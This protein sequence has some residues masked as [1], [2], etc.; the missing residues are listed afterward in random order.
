MR[1]G[2]R[3]NAK[4]ALTALA[5]V[6]GLPWPI[7]QPATEPAIVPSHTPPTLEDLRAAIAAAPAGAAGTNAPPA[8]T[9]ALIGLV[10][11]LD[12]Q[13]LIARLVEGLD[14][15]DRRDPSYGKVLRVVLAARSPLANTSRAIELLSYGVF[16]WAV[17]DWETRLAYLLVRSIPIEA[18]DSWRQLDNGKWLGRLLDN[19]P[20]D[21][22]ESG[23]YTGVGSEYS[24]G[25]VNLGVPETMLLGYAKGY[26]QLWEAQAHSLLAKWIVRNLLALDF[27]GDP[28]PWLPTDAAKD[29]A[30]RTAVI[31]RLDALQG[32]NGIIEKL[33]DDYLLGEQTRQELL[34]LNQLR[35][36]VHLVRQALGLMPGFFG[37]I[38]FT[39]HD[40]WIALQA[41]RALS[42]AAQQQLAAQNPSVWSTFWEGLTDEM[43]RSLPSTLATGRDARL[44]TRAALRERLS[45]ERLWTQ[46]NAAV[47]RALIDLA[48]AADDRLWVFELS[49][50]LRI[51]LKVAQAPLVA[52]VLRDFG[53]YSVAER[54]TVFEPRRT[55]SSH[56]PMGLRSLGVAAKGLALLAYHLFASDAEISLMGKTMHLKAFDLTD[57]QW[58]MGGDF[59]G[60]TLGSSAG[61]ANHVNVDATFADGFIVNLDMPRLDVAGV[62]MV[63]P[64]KSYKAGPLTIEG[65]KVSA[66]FSDRGYTRPGYIAA[67][68]DALALRDFVVIDPTLPLAG[69]WA[70]AN[71]GVNRLGF[72]A[73]PDGATDPS[74][75]IGRDLPKGTIPIPV[76]GPLFQLLSNIVSLKGSIPGD[77]TLL[78]YAMLPLKL[79]F[80]V[81]TAASFAANKAIPTP[82]PATYL[83][84]LASDGVLRPPYS[85]AQRIK[86][87]TAMLRAF[88]VAFDKLEVK[89]ITIGA[90]QQI[91][92]LTLTD[93]NITVGQSLPAYLRAALATVHAARVKAPADSPQSIELEQRERAL[94]KQLDAALGEDAADEKRLQALEG[95]DRWHPGSLSTEDRAELVRL[96][97]KLRSDVGVVAEI[98]SISLGPLT[99]AVQ[100]PGVTLTG[101]HARAKLPNLGILPYAPGYL[102]DKSLI[103]QFAE[104][105]PKVPTIGEL[106]KTSEFHLEIDE[107]T[108]AKTDPAQ[109][110]VVLRA[111]TIPSVEAL[112][113]EI[114]ALPVIEGN[115][116]IRQR[117]TQ[118]LAAVVSLQAAKTDVR[119][120]TTDDARRAAEQRVRELTELARRL[121]GTEIGGLKFGRITGDLDPAGNLSVSVNDIE[122][123]GIAGRG[124]A[125]DK[126]V[127]TA[128]IGLAAGNIDARLDQVGAVSPQTLVTQLKPAFGLSGLTV[129]GVHLPSGS[130]GRVVLGKL[131]GTLVTNAQGYSV[132]NLV[133]DHLEVGDVA[134]GRDGDGI[135][136]EAVTIDDLRF[137]IDVTIGRPA[138][139][140]PAVTGAVIPNLTIG[141]LSGRGIV[142]D[143]PQPDGSTTHI[144][145]SRGTLRDIR[146]TDIAFA[147][148]SKGWQLV[149]AKATVGSFEDV[150]FQLAMGALSSR[151]T[152][153][154][155]LTT[156]TKGRSG[157]P[158]FS[159]SYAQ[160]DGGPTVSLRVRDLLARGTDV[161]TPDGSLTVRSVRVAADY[162]SDPKGGRA[163]ASF[164]GLVIGPIRW[165]VGT[166][167][168]SGDGPLT[169]DYT[170]LAAVQTP[171]VPA[172]GKKPA[173]PAA[174]TV[175]DVVITKL[176]GRKLNW[177]DKPLSL[178][179]GRSDRTGTGEPP[180]TVGRIHLRPAA[181]SFELADLAVD[182]EGKITDTLGVKGS[183]SADFISVDVLRG[184]KLHAVVRGV[185]GSASLSG[186]YTGTVELSGLQGAAV[187]VGPDAIRI[188]SD[189]PAETGGLFIEQ[190]SAHS[191]DITTVVGGHKA[192]LFTQPP[193]MGKAGGRIDLLGIRTRVR[194]DKR[195]PPEKGKSPFKTL[196]FETFTI[197][198]IVLDALQVDLPDDD[199]S[200]VIQ[201]TATAA[202]E[203][204]IRNLELTSPVGTDRA[205]LH[206]DFT[207]DLDTFK[208]EGTASIAG[209][210]AGVSAKIKDK[211]TGDVRFS[212]GKSDLYLYAG[213]GMRIDVTKPLVELKKAADIGGGRSVR[214]G[215]LGAESLSYTDDGHL[216]V[217]KPFASDLEYIQL[218]PGTSSRAV[219]IKVK[220][221]DL[222]QLDYNT[223]GGGSLSIPSLDIT[224]AFFSL[225]LGALT[226]KKPGDTAD[227]AA[228]TSSFDPKSLRPAMNELNGSLG[229]ELYVSSDIFGLKDIHIGTDSKPLVVPIVAGELDIPTFESNIKGA[230]HAVQ[231]GE[232]LYL[233]P[234]VVNAVANDPLLAIH[235]NRLELG[236][237][238]VNP[239]TGVEKGNDVNEKNR[240]RTKLWKPI[241]SWDLRAADLAR[242]WSNKF[243]LWSAVFDMH[244]DP[245]KTDEDLAK[246]S[247]SDRKE[248]EEDQK[249]AKEM[250]KSLEI[251]KLDAAFSMRNDRPIPIPISSETVKGSIML[252][253]DAL[254]N[255][256]VKGGIP[257]EVTPI[258][259]PGTNPGK[260][261]L[262][263]DFFNLDSV[264]LTIY[265]YAPPD[266]KG[267][268]AK[269]TGMSGLRTGKITIDTLENASV[270]FF[271]LKHPGRLTGTIKKAHAENISWSKY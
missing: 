127:G 198:R 161:T 140:A 56:V 79:P 259:R 62:N 168:L 160:G 100:S 11:A 81:S 265:D 87:S 4:Q 68:F 118:A 214:V 226:K 35:D 29:L 242:A 24:T 41:L 217:K 2:G 44:P 103:D 89:G 195:T 113:A 213:G 67:K 22:W 199:V 151:T 145:A 149:R 76:F 47:L 173:R 146:G 241:L 163:T 37:L 114:D 126:A 112:Q 237:Y 236:V 172:V 150:G 135:Q 254:L 180:L 266:K 38:T 155:T 8:T 162:A 253:K 247:E 252:G 220:T 123:T 255:L 27:S 227:D 121:L 42:P 21:M 101:I 211:F 268:P 92:S 212:A 25:A 3:D 201:R 229:V 261:D 142:M 64:G 228:S 187:D 74:V 13:G 12:A 193:G 232:G 202:D 91:A 245:P 69:A 240:P 166:A 120:A 221:V 132:P 192:H 207:I 143:S 106:A 139:G 224:D 30:L 186:D 130:I 246:L 256:R 233:R 194:I 219:W 248:Y 84:G 260:L 235:S 200:I 222:K 65:F 156:A 86:D 73:T 18:Q 191:L 108:L 107:T 129:T 157:Q 58:M 134:M 171:P 94:Q 204:F 133:V 49:R 66:G 97:K 182:V 249:A 102:D 57:V 36:P 98:G 48:V 39:P 131:T 23:E 218:V 271:D 1:E 128:S 148:D 50:R 88:N 203:T 183:L 257:A 119:D 179:L 181:K 59:D 190:L 71:L 147:A 184:D 206:P 158:T 60:V 46:A 109:P 43:R 215:K 40:A 238:Y 264:N 159:A 95:K 122:A 82:A 250:M 116:P 111:D 105:G 34:D 99:G 141:A 45:D 55:E 197:D 90:G 234:W 7:S 78:D 51:D 125:I 17:R 239:P 176:T 77:F 75:N 174:W 165:K 136:A 70:V 169:A 31:R 230:I 20:S 63:L 189:D 115:R 251:R 52:A 205:K 185:S 53:L 164:S 153:K 243:S 262:G 144:A 170:T 267:D 28:N 124:F 85:A 263:L 188:G 154:G 117:L 19:L 5:H 216:Y 210:S 167:V 6:C 178:D 61:G 231:I 26:L 32:L 104:G 223:A 209:L 177:T 196:A 54:R 225:N 9:P 208:I 80:P 137:G 72:N 93:V 270:T 15:E 33:P 138:G 16:D 96:S 152:V 10:A 269:L 110:A 258:E 244:S 83:W 14:E 175:T